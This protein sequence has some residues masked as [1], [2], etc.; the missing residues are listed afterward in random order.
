MSSSEKRKKNQTH[1]IGRCVNLLTHRLLCMCLCS[2][3]RFFSLSFF[4]RYYS[5]STA[6]EFKKVK[7]IALI[8]IIDVFIVIVLISFSH[9]AY[10]ST[11][12]PQHQMIAMVKIVDNFVCM[13]VVCRLTFKTYKLTGLIFQQALS[14]SLTSPISTMD[15]SCVFLCNAHRMKNARWK[16]NKPIK[17]S[18]PC[19]SNI[20]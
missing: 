6:K 16:N 8:T 17:N 2:N 11:Q 20:K 15:T 5:I 7:G 4:S 9:H 10:I 1:R 13:A 12:K 3:A 14:L 19:C 18:R